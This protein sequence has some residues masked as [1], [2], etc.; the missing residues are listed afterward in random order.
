MA[1]PTGRL[2]GKTAIVTGASS[3]IGRAIALRYASE[4]AKVVC[5]DLTPKARGAAAGDEEEID[6][7]V[8]IE[9][10]GGEA[11]FVDADVGDAGQMERLVEAAVER[12]GRVDV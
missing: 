10:R 1:L 3:G 4:G 12:F 8:L 2:A 7:H 9:Q 5:A 6:T 11:A